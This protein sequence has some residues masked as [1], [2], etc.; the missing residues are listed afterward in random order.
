MTPR[1][2]KVENVEKTEK[3]EKVEK[4]K[5]TETKISTPPESEQKEIK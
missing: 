5:K 2:I 1:M 4:T 3:V